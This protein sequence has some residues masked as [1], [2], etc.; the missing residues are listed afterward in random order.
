MEDILNILHFCYILFIYMKQKEQII[1]PAFVSLFVNDSKNSCIYYFR[2]LTN[3]NKFIYQEFNEEQLK[4]EYTKQYNDDGSIIYIFKTHVSSIN[5]HLI[6][7]FEYIKDKI[8]K[9]SQKS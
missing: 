2:G 9:I 8:I 3:T 7:N 4:G 5:C 1:F 6:S